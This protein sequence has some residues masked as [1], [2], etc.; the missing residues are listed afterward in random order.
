[1]YS[2]NDGRTHIDVRARLIFILVAHSHTV[3]F[4]T[5]H[6]YGRFDCIWTQ[7]DAFAKPNRRILFLHR[8]NWP[9][10]CK[11]VLS[12][13]ETMIMLFDDLVSFMLL[14]LVMS[15]TAYF[16]FVIVWQRDFWQFH[17]FW[18]L[19]HWNLNFSREILLQQRTKWNDHG[20]S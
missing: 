4:L 14:V 5:D 19:Q 18:C 7:V 6:L 9:V 1:M 17:A 13:K 12:S 20:Y 15:I 3:D 16:I 11:I 10:W 8:M 2:Q